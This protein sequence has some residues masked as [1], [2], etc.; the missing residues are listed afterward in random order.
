MFC[1]PLGSCSRQVTEALLVPLLSSCTAKTTLL[2]LSLVS[3][4]TLCNNFPDNYKTNEKTPVLL[5]G[6][7]HSGVRHSSCTESV[8]NGMKKSAAWEERSQRHEAVQ[9]PCEEDFKYTA[10][11]TTL[12]ETER[13]FDELTH[14]KQQAKIIFV[15]KLWQ[16]VIVVWEVRDGAICPWNA[17]LKFIHNF[18]VT[19][20]MFHYPSLL[21]LQSFPV[22]KFIKGESLWHK[23]CGKGLAQYY[24]V[25]QQ[26][27]TC[28]CN[29]YTSPLSVRGVR[30]AHIGSW[31]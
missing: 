31:N 13:L 10:R 15:F 23:Q 12:A 9:S 26:N 29:P 17:W 3:F 11:I 2:V 22:L 30:K 16:I 24:G 7:Q 5:I 8:S 20:G 1:I 6:R 21:Y 25:K 14:E 18:S 28:I 19:S 27:S 4:S